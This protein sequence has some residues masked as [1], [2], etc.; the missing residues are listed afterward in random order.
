MLQE[1][2][3]AH[4]TTVNADKSLRHDYN[5]LLQT[6]DPNFGNTKIT[7]SEGVA[8][9]DPKTP[10]TKK[11]EVVVRAPDS[12]SSLLAW[13]RLSYWAYGRDTNEEG[14]TTAID[15][16]ES[17]YCITP[18]AAQKFLKAAK[19]AAREEETEFRDEFE[20]YHL[21]E[22][23]FLYLDIPSFNRKYGVKKGLLPRTRNLK[24]VVAEE[25]RLVR[26]RLRAGCH[27][28]LRSFSMRDGKYLRRQNGGFLV[29]DRVAVAKYFREVFA[30]QLKTQVA[31]YEKTAKSRDGTEAGSFQPHL[32]VNMSL[33]FS[34]EHPVPGYRWSTNSADWEHVKDAKED[35]QEMKDIAIEVK[36]EIIKAF[37]TGTQYLGTDWVLER[38]RRRNEVLAEVG[39]NWGET[40]VRDVYLNNMRKKLA[41]ERKEKEGLLSSRASA[42]T[43]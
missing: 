12:V 21:G 1:L 2:F 20:D 15:E 5:P 11:E 10:F 30:H 35:R 42:R 31:E 43:E 25:E 17:W 16:Y 23:D 24:N 18:D 6:V 13:D 14:E 3:P 41:E 19:N 34:Q 4:K 26:K 28:A 36:K 7:I 32:D 38:A 22:E 29:G 8:R 37:E 40:H 33:P 27:R 39:G 9:G